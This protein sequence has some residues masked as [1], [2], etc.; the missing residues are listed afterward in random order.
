MTRWYLPSKT[1][2]LR[3]DENK[4]TYYHLHDCKK[5]TSESKRHDKRWEKVCEF[6][7][8]SLKSILHLLS[9]NR[10]SGLLYL[11][12]YAIDVVGTLDERFCNHDIAKYLELQ[13]RDWWDIERPFC[14]INKFVEAMRSE[15]WGHDSAAM[16]IEQIGRRADETA[17]A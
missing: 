7:D 3:Y 8:G 13:T 15:K 17:T 2:P 16:L 14:I 12:D 5:S 1:C 11:L 6:H 4:T 9:A 10:P